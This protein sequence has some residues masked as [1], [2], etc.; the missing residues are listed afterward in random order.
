M[1]R[2]ETNKN[3]SS[4]VLFIFLAYV[5]GIAIFSIPNH[6]WTHGAVYSERVLKRV[7]DGVTAV[8]VGGIP[9]LMIVLLYKAIFP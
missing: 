4:D 7:L 2:P 5:C 9:A 1:G 8:I 6:E 3:V